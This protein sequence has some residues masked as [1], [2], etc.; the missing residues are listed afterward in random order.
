MTFQ[1]EFASAS[2]TRS[3]RHGFSWW[4]Q[5][6]FE[7][8]LILISAS[9]P[10]I[11]FFAW[12]PFIS[13]LVA[14]LAITWLAE[15]DLINRFK[16]MIRQPIIL[17]LIAVYLSLL[18]GMIHTQDTS[19]GWNSLLLK[20]PLLL[21]PLIFSTSFVSRQTFRWMLIGFVTATLVGTA[22]CLIRILT[23][24][25]SA[26]WQVSYTRLSNV[27]NLHPTIFS[28]Y[29]AFA[30]VAATYLLLHSVRP[31][32]W[33]MIA[34]IP[35]WLWFGLN[36]ILL[37][38]R[39]GLIVMFLLVVVGAI[40]LVVHRR[41]L[42][43]AVMLAIVAA[44]T[45]ESPR[46]F[47]YTI[48]RVMVAV[49]VVSGGA[50]DTRKVLWEESARL[51]AR[52]PV[53][54]VGTGDVEKELFIAL[55]ETHAEVAKPDRHSHNQYL[56][57]ALAIGIPGALLLMS[58]L[59]WPLV[60]SMRR[61]YAVYAVFLVSVMVFLIFD[62]IWEIQSGL[63]FY[64]FF[65]AL[66]VIHLGPQS[67]TRAQAVRILQRGGV[68]LHQTDTI[69]GIAC[70]ATDARAVKR[71]FAIK[72][73]DESKPMLLLCADRQMASRFVE[74]PDEAN[75][76]LVLSLEIP[77]TIV[78]KNV[79]API[80]GITTKDGTMAVRVPA[81]ASLRELLTNVGEPLVSTSAN[82]SGTPAPAQFSKVSWRI[83]RSVD[84]VYPTSVSD[85]LFPGKPSTM[86]ELNKDGV[87]VIRQGAG[88]ERIEALLGSD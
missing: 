22:Y 83:R 21:F 9:I 28:M 64:A 67:V 20:L 80:Q 54:G 85:A 52:Y 2:L 46:L 13:Y 43:A 70:M 69:P 65:N 58:S 31:S 53:F 10:F 7:W 76:L 59:L 63:I 41:W 82:V 48:S 6:L 44:V 79:R 35:M 17:L 74:V 78:Y 47:G 15:G 5:G 61:R 62:G 73:R 4:R 77:V 39:A 3:S 12:F 24:G 86:I 32:L 11:Q 66:M 72:G 19:G 75:D 57:T 71:V 8:Q 25:I 55:S 45:I 68:I 42:W 49:N 88:Y 33:R 27:I 56:Q 26:T 1:P 84:C 18:F 36:M 50:P 16:S 14:L 37:S 29:I 40:T 81:S 30:A 38:S 51:V 87:E 23:E 34:L 60:F